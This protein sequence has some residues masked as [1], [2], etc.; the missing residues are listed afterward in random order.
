M[1]KLGG[2][3]QH[4]DGTIHQHLRKDSRA[5]CLID[6]LAERLPRYAVEDAELSAWFLAH[7]ADPNAACMMDKTPLS[8]AV[9]YA[10]LSVVHMLFANGGDIEQGQLL[11]AAV[12]RKLDDRRTMVEYLLRKGADV[13]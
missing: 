5:L 12:W 9:Q 10:P 11:H 13:P 1:R 6:L 4:W 2:L 3:I 7:G 8:A